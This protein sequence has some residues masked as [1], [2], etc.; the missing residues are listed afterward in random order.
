MPSLSVYVSGAGSRWSDPMRTM[1]LYGYALRELTVRRVLQ[2]KAQK[3][4]DKTFLTFLPDGRRYSYRTLDTYSNQIGNALLERGVTRGTHVAVIMDNCPEQILLYMALAKIGAVAVPVN[5]AAKGSLLTYFLTQSD[6]TVVV[7]EGVYAERVAEIAQTVPRITR[8]FVLGESGPSVSAAASVHW[9]TQDWQVLMQGAEAPIDIE[10]LPTDLAMLAYTSGT[11]GPSK[12]NMVLQATV[13]QFGMSTAE[14]HGYRFDDIAY[15]C[16]PVNHTNAFLNATWGALIA[17]AAVALARRFS[18]SGFW[19]DIRG[20]GATLANI[21][22]SMVNMIWAQPPRD[23]DTD[24][25][26][27]LVSCIPTPPFALEFERRFGTRLVAAYG[28]TDYCNA[29]VYT[30]L[31]PVG[32][33]GSS[34]RVRAGIEIAIVD[35]LDWPAPAG[36]VGEIVIRSHNLWGASQGYY[37]MPEATLQT[38]RNLWFH[39]GD[40]GYLDTDGFLFFTGRKKDSIR[41]RGENVSAQEVETILATHPDIVDA[42]VFAV[43]SD[44]AEEEIVA[45]LIVRAGSNLDFPE[46]IQFAA[47]QMAYYMVPRYVQVLQDFPRTQ[48]QKVEK[49]KLRDAAERDLGALWDREAAGIIVKR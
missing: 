20:S 41:R 23:N 7:L 29:T 27:R 8:T 38:L 12:G 47:K 13:C 31:D 14:S 26:L 49:F 1:N 15:V 39:T 37:K 35:E 24:N 11:T 44:M 10:V 3:N 45:A 5:T 19:S 9:E 40:L 32:K 25:R 36:T 30:L 34:G 16:L 28:L 4:G 48:S 6:S 42:A 46:F 21:L 33:I 18:V 2:D 22:G 17:D 43:K